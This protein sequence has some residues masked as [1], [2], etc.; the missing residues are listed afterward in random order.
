VVFL[1]QNDEKTH[2]R[3]AIFETQSVF[4]REG[5]APTVDV[6]C[7]GIVRRAEQE[8]GAVL[9]GS[10]FVVH[11]KDALLVCLVYAPLRGEILEGVG[12]ARSAFTLPKP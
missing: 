11:L 6:M 3:H 9:G 10:G 12:Q 4:R 1:L 2:S 7:Q 5:T 8:D